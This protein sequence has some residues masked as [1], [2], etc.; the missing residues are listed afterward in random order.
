MIQRPKDHRPEAER[1]RDAGLDQAAKRRPDRVMLG[2]LAMLD[3]LLQS[4]DGTAT[5][6]D[7]T[8]PKEFAAGYRDGGFWRGQITRSLAEAGYIERIGWRLSSRPTRHRSPVSIWR[9]V[10]RA[11]A[12]THRSHLKA[13]INQRK[14]GPAVAPDEPADPD[15]HTNSKEKANG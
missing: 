13:V 14:T 15:T 1:L 9:L 4:P 5:I 8:P 10:D 3:A 6:D 2:R 12:T 11:A 7:A